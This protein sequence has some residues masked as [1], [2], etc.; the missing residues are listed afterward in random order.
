MSI[1]TISDLAYPSSEAIS[2]P[3]V[4]SAPENTPTTGS[5]KLLSPQL[6]RRTLPMNEDEDDEVASVTHSLLTSAIDYSHVAEQDFSYDMPDGFVP[7]D[8]EGAYFYPIYVKNPKYGKWDREPRL[9]LAPFVQYSLDFTYITG[10]AGKN[11]ERRVVPVFIGRKARFFQKMTTGKWNDLKRGSD[12]EFAVNEAVTMATDPR[13]KGELNRFRGKDDLCNTLREMLSDAQ[14][15][16]GK[17][18]ERLVKEREELAQS[19]HRLEEA[20]VYEEL[21]RYYRLAFPIPIPPR[22]SPVITAMEPRTRGPVE[23]PILMDEPRK[24]MRSR[25]NTRCFKCNKY[26]HKKSEC[27]AYKPRKAAYPTR[28]TPEVER[29]PINTGE[30][31]LLD[32]IALMDR[33][34]WTPQYCTKC[35]KVNANH[36]EYECHRYEECPRC[37]NSGS[38]GFVKHH[39]C[40]PFEGGRDDMLEDGGVDEELYWNA[41]D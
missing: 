24:K 1:A 37:R 38:F 9:M 30:F 22:H 23:F 14:R 11:E 17:L 29:V 19:M 40:N 28:T 25:R 6:G 2:T 21:D 5:P 13:L 35:G 36:T 20:N 7:N 8:P 33:K 32:R 34:E 15:R 27:M 26:G 3:S 41:F 12:Q 10:S 39:H 16:V 31:T 4:I 18:Q